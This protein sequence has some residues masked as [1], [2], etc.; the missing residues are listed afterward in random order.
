MTDYD[1]QTLMIISKRLIPQYGSFSVSARYRDDLIFEAKVTFSIDQELSEQS[2]LYQYFGPLCEQSSAQIVPLDKAREVVFFIKNWLIDEFQNLLT[3]DFSDK[4]KV[5]Y[6]L[7]RICDDEQFF[8]LHYNYDAYDRKIN[9]HSWI[10]C[11]PPAYVVEVDN[12]FK[13]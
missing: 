11:D 13:D 2:K 1:P 8:C 5:G 3:L 9:H 6:F 12:M 4:N 10:M 7:M